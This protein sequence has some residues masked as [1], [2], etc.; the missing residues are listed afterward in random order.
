MSGAHVPGAQLQS[1]TSTWGWQSRYIR[2]QAQR[3]QVWARWTPQITESGFY[4]VSVFVPVRHAST[5]RARYKIHGVKGSANNEVLVEVPQNRYYNLWVSLGVY[6]FDANS[7]RAGIV[8]LNDLTGEG[9]KE[10]AFDAVRFRQIINNPAD[11]RYLADGYDAPIGTAAERAAENMWPGFW[12]DATGY[13]VHYFRGTPAEAY[14]T[15]ADLNLNRPYFDADRDAPV[16]AAASGTVTFSNRLS[17][18]GWLIVVRHDPLVSTGQTLYGRYAHVNKP[19]VKVG[20]RVVRGQQMANVGNADGNF[21]YH[22]H[23]DLSH[24]RILE[25]NPGHWPKMNL[26]QVLAHYLDPREFVAKNRPPLR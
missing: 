8:F 1:F 19:A 18:W 9:D 11:S 20:D 21:A 25:T 14:H 12:L 15:G 26:N 2:T 24:T 17:G 6:E 13:A 4:D 7:G 10:I 5:D 16:Y 3:S 22:L 23:F